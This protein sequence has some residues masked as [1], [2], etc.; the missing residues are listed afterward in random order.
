[1][2]ATNR[3][4][5]LRRVR[6][7]L[8][9]RNTCPGWE[10]WRVLSWPGRT[11]SIHPL[12]R[13]QRPY[14]LNKK[15]LAEKFLPVQSSNSSISLCS[16]LHGHKTESARVTAVGI[17]HDLRFLNLFPVVCNESMQK[18]NFNLPYQLQR[19]GFP[20]LCCQHGGSS[21]RRGGYSQDYD[22]QERN[23]D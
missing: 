6:D 19:S 16:T 3:N 22:R 18:W 5:D 10:S 9:G 8:G 14:F 2:N 17:T 15:G 20:S 21:Q 4:R 11:F 1:M 13:E 12:W 7:V 23:H